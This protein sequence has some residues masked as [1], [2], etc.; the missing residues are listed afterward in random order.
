MQEIHVILKWLGFN[1]SYKLKVLGNPEFDGGNVT[2][3]V[4]IISKYLTW[5]NF[6][7]KRL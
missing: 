5:L 3:N 2:Y 1:Y 6:R 4:K 7:I